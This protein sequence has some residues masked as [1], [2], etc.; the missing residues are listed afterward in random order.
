MIVDL[1]DV[2]FLRSIAFLFRIHDYLLNEVTPQWHLD[3]S[4]AYYR[5]YLVLANNFHLTLCHLSLK[6]FIDVF[7]QI[8]RLLLHDR[9]SGSN[10]SESHISERVIT[11]R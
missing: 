4:P 8:N 2:L 9:I 6:P 3:R 11:K 5:V 1:R 7:F 10:T